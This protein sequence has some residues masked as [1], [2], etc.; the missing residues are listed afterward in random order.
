[1][2]ITLTAR[3]YWS[4]GEYKQIYLLEQSGDISP[5]VSDD[6]HANDFNSS[7]L[8]VDLVYN[9]EFAPGS[10]FIVT[11]KNLILSETLRNTANY[12]TNLSR[13]FTDP[14]INSISLKVLYYLDYQYLKKK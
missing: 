3:H 1:M 8:T 7:Y 12:V 10:S 9:W 11:Y 5:V 13:T 4:R 14:Q 2:S 6:V